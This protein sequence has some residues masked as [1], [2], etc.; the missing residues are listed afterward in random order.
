MRLVQ[1]KNLKEGDIIA[2]DVI[3]LEGGIL[4]KH[5]TRFKEAY[6]E[7]LIERNIFE[8]FIEDELSKGI[9]PSETLTNEIKRKINAD[10]K[11][12]FDKLRDDIAIDPKAI[13]ETAKLMIEQLQEK[14]MVLELE[15][16]RVN[17]NYTYEHCIAVAILSNVVCNK[18]RL[19]QEMKEQ[20][21]MGA[22]IHDIGKVVIPK[23][24]LNKPGQLT[25][26]E[27]ALIKTHAEVG[28][29]MIKS[30]PQIS[31]ITKLA[32]L[33]HHERED[34]SGYP[35]KKKEE[36]HIS[37]KIVAACDLFHA[38]IS[39]RCYRKGL[40]LNEVIA[41]AEKQAINPK[42]R[43]IIIHSLCYY[44]VGCTVVLN[45]GRLAIVEKNYAANIK[46]P[47]I[48][49]IEKADEKYIFSYKVDLLT[50]TKLEIVSRY[51]QPYS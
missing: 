36:L 27:Y 12:Q 42:I 4:L 15:E 47:L 26:E 34:G 23:D 44:P 45:D 31:A 33:C 46:R 13:A 18:L 39:D 16:L 37:A 38:L 3:G 20:I 11:E 32:V 2:R 7:K 30:N 49:V 50:E 22:L 19:N 9:E 28:Y 51:E 10:I 35:L 1:I 29:S 8:V 25:E 6:R 17:D 21:V 43:D 41:I 24:I 5:R 40:P 48:R 14:E